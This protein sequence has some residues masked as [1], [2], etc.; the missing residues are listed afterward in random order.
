MTKRNA[1]ATIG[2]MMTTFGS[3][4]AAAHAVEA[5]RRPRARDLVNLGIEPK[6]FEN[7][8]RYY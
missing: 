8:R 6:A 4:I 7:I 2:A 3:A 1:F 5:G